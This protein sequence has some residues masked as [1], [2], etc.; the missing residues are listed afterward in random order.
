MQREQRN[1]GTEEVVGYLQTLFDLCTLLF[2]IISEC[3]HVCMNAR[4]CAHVC[5]LQMPSLY[6]PPPYFFE[7]VSFTEPGACCV[8][9]IDW[10]VS[11]RDTP[12]FVP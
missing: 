6:F 12:G 5:Q 11:F 7:T 10:P 3:A 8:D 2:F 4:V 9:Y 1:S